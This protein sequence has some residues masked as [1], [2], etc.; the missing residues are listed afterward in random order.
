MLEKE[1]EYVQEFISSTNGDKSP[2]EL[3][4]FRHRCE[5]VVRVLNW[6]NRIIESL[7]DNKKEELDLYAIR[8]AAVFHDVAYGIEHFKNSHGIEGAMIFKEYAL[9]NNFDLELINKVY[10]MI[11]IHQDKTLLK[12]NISEELTILIEADMLDEE[13]A[14]GIVWDLLTL[15]NFRPKSYK[16]ALNKIESYSAK[17]LKENPMKHQ[18]AF[19]EWAKKQE[20]VKNFILSLKQDLFL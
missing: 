2:R 15:G 1:I 11:Y 4:T 6:V 17:I 16:E 12:Q 19:N 18:Y 3:E 5:H 9:K 13:G 10:N 14:M 8:L 7:D 20:L